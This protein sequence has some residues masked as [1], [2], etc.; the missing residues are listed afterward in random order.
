MEQMIDAPGR[1]RVQTINRRSREQ[2][3]DPIAQ[4]QESTGAGAR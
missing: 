3:S 4:R 2:A 1:L